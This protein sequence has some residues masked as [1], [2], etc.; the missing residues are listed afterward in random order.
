M[1]NNCSFIEIVCAVCSNVFTL[2]L[3]LPA[4]RPF[5]VEEM[6]LADIAKPG[7]RF[8]TCGDHMPEIL[9]PRPPSIVLDNCHF[10]TWPVIEVNVVDT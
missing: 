6:L 2:E 1:S 10:L 9:Q 5:C 4:L 8:Q 3:M 7:N